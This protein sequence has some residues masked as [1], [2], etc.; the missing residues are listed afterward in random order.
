M[1]T[2]NTVKKEKCGAN[3]QRC[4]SPVAATENAAYKKMKSQL[5]KQLQDAQNNIQALKK[6]L[7]SANKKQQAII[8][9][10]SKKERLL[11]AGFAKKQRYSQKN[12]NNRVKLME[13]QWQNQ[14]C[15]K[16]K[17]LKQQA[18]KEGVH[19]GIQE[20]ER[21]IRQISQQYRAALTLPKS[22]QRPQ[23]DKNQTQRRATKP[24]NQKRAA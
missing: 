20:G 15:E 7:Q 8:E 19:R 4:Q 10:A 1:S 18:F 23:S 22:M 11:K 2:R 16:I 9:R 6:Q 3:S 13:R 17:T 21:C 24:R 12:F 5:E 14:L